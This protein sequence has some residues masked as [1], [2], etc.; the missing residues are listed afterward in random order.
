MANLRTKLLESINIGN[1]NKFTQIMKFIPVEKYNQEQS[2]RLLG[3]TLNAIARS[4]SD[5]KKDLARVLI[6]RWADK[7]LDGLEIEGDYLSVFESLFFNNNVKYE[8]LQFVA[9]IYSNYPLVRIV[10]DVIETQYNNSGRTYISFGLK[11]I[12]KVYKGTYTRPEL[13]F[14][15]KEA[16]KLGNNQAIVFLNNVISTQFKVFAKKPDW[17]VPIGPLVEESKIK[18]TSKEKIGTMSNSEF[19]KI[20]KENYTQSK[21][22][23]LNFD[24]ITKKVSQMSPSEKMS[25]ARPLLEDVIKISDKKYFQAYGPSNPYRF[26]SEEDMRDSRDRMLQCDYFEINPDTFESS[27]FDGVCWMCQDH[28]KHK[29]YSV[30]AP[31]PNGG[32]KGWFCSWSCTARWIKE[33]NEYEDIELFRTAILI[34]KFQEEINIYKI[35]DRLPDTKPIK[36]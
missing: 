18:P 12:F 36:L 30:R 29:W 15:A 20:V 4:K 28:I 3:V 35:R 34:K 7:G 13:N 11:R 23:V 33:V 24:Q 6:Y 10:L 1:L 16:L 22:E 9:P 8:S 21:I 27:A 32:W 26:P 31:I 25:M 14:L 5:F 19:L 2:D 17:V